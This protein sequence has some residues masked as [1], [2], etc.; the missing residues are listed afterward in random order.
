MG[1]SPPTMAASAILDKAVS[2]ETVVVFSKE[3]CP[4]CTRAKSA[5]KPIFPGMKIIELD[6]GNVT[7]DGQTASGSSV[8]DAIKSKYGHRTVP[9]VFIKGKLIG[10][11][12]DTLAGISNGSIKQMLA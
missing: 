12:D 2:A 4:F 6:Q 8:Q 7:Y 9:A 5:L 10:G 3:Y 1:N 11:C